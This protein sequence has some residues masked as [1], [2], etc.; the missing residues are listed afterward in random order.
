MFKFHFINILLVIGVSGDRLLHLQT[1]FRH[2]DRAPVG[3]YK[4][5]PYQADSWPVAWG[6]LTDDGMNQHFEQGMKIQEKYMFENNFLPQTYKSA[7]IYVRSSDVNR[8]LMSGLSHL[9][10]LYSNSQGTHPNNPHWPT[11]WSPIPIHTVDH[12]SDSLLNPSFVCL[13]MDELEAEQVAHKD[14][15]AYMAA[16]LPF[17]EFISNHTGESITSFKG[18]EDFFD[19]I[20]IEKIHNMTL[21][22]WITDSVYNQAQTFMDTCEDYVYGSAG[23]NKPENTELLKLKGGMLLKEMIS[24]MDTAVGNNGTGTKLHVYSAHD[25]TVAA[26]LRV[27]GAK[28]GVLGL[29][30]PDFAATLTVELWAGSDGTNYVKIWYADNAPTNFRDVTHSIGNCGGTDKCPLDTFKTRSQP[31]IPDDIVKDCDKL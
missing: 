15:L 31:Y 8:T 1:L 30:Q 4:N 11:N 25:T 9:A 21:P 16:Q 20:R 14:F 24:N 22:S 23:F 7:D 28:E 3:P 5:D 2:G 19:A 12:D 26:F 18:F 17:L 6:E 27:L 13:R 29:D 10:S